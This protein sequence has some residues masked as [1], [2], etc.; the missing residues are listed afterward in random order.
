V[1]SS[2]LIPV[3]ITKEDLRANSGRKITRDIYLTEVA[4]AISQKSGV[5][6]HVDLSKGIVYA[7]AV[8]NDY[9]NCN[10]LSILEL[11]NQAKKT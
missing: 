2:P 7:Y 11:N 9:Y 10:S 1:S 6:A 5:A 3:A 4:T 8:H